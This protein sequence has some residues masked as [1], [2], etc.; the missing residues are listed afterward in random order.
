MARHDN[1]SQL[2]KTETRVTQ[3]GFGGAALG[4]LFSVVTEQDGCEALEQA[5]SDGIRYFDTAPYYGYGLSEQ[6]VGK[7]LAGKTR[8]EFCLSTKVGRLLSADV[9]RPAKDEF[10]HPLPLGAVFDY[11]Y[12]ATWACVET[13]LQRLGLAR[14]D[15]ALV[16]DLD[17]TVHDTETL[18]HYLGEARTGAFRALEEMRVSGV[19]TAIGLGLNE[20]TMAE[21]LIGELDLD[22]V[23]L[24]GR[25]TLLE[26]EASV[27]FLPECERRGVS[28]IIGGPFNSGVLAGDSHSFY[29]YAPAPASVAKKVERL[30]TICVRHEVSLTAAALQFPLRHPAV[31]AVIPGMRDASQ[32]KQNVESFDTDIPE[33]LWEELSLEGMLSI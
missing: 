29:D 7:V 14:I 17:Q 12:D 13:S 8:D 19:V 1:V 25:Y 9:A 4:N 21:Q 24:A 15:V 22:V 20:C 2:G 26:Q 32:V 11:R 28:V 5:W 33:R 6:R 18:T 16:H 10:V 27:S 31:A 30:R 3:L 23:L